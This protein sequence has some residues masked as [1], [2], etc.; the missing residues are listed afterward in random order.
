MLLTKTKKWGNSLSVI[1]PKELVRQMKLKENQEIAIELKPKTNVLNELF[2]FAKG[3]VN[4]TTEE[5]RK[6]ARKDLSKHF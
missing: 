6:E 2:G 1:I 4:K 3:K 5:I